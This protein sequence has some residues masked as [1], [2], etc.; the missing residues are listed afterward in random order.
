METMKQLTLKEAREIML[1]SSKKGTRC[2]CCHRIVKIYARP[3]TSAMCQALHLIV[4][5]QRKINEEGLPIHVET[6]LKENAPNAAVRGDFP[7][8][9]FWGLIEPVGIA[10]KTE[11]NPST[12]YYRV[13][14]AG[15]SFVDNK[16]TLPSHVDIM[17]NQYFGESTKALKVT[18][19][20]CMRNTFDY[21]EV[22][23]G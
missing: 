2:P 9:R 14:D 8:L 23:H 11:G 12:G 7:K 1:S 4:A 22:I 20:E 3:L 6:F 15:R 10:L 18:F 5:Y 21:Q 13:T 16:L 17:D 19:Q